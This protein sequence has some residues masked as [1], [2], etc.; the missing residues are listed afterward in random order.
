M[1]RAQTVALRDLGI[2]GRTSPERPALGQKLGTGS[3]VDCAI[4]AASAK[5]RRICGVDDGVN[6]ECR[7]VGDDNLELGAAD[8]ARQLGHVSGRDGDALLGEQ[9]LQFAGLEH[10]ADDVAAADELALHIELRNG[11]PVRDS[12]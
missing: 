1:S 3:V 4:N 11:R 2:A 8:P 9:L 5:E 6:A 7:D 10:L 12:P